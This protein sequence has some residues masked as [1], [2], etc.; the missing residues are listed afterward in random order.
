M[1]SVCLIASLVLLSAAAP[2]AVA[3]EPGAANE[4]VSPAL[5]SIGT[6][7]RRVERTD[8]RFVLLPTGEET[9]RI[10]DSAYRTMGAE[11]NL[12]LREGYNCY[13]V[14]FEHAHALIHCQIASAEDF[15]DHWI[16]DAR[17]GTLTHVKPTPNE[18]H[19]YYR[20][21][22]Y[23]L[24]GFQDFPARAPEGGYIYFLNWWTGAFRD[25]DDFRVGGPRDLDS[26]RLRPLKKRKS[27]YSLFWSNQRKS[28]VS[29]LVYPKGRG[30]FLYLR[31]R[32]CDKTIDKR[33]ARCPRGRCAARLDPELGVVG[34]E[35]R[36]S[37]RRW[38]AGAYRIAT[39]NK[40]NWEITFPE[41]EP[42]LGV[43]QIPTKFANFLQVTQPPN[44]RAYP[45]R[46]Y[47]AR[48]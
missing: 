37:S 22:R 39:R 26:R 32:R 13:P 14:D 5:P 12:A 19:P 3:Q 42:D 1:R 25:Y 24:Q 47:E 8:G 21:G 41:D 44:Y 38:T 11:V 7:D 18:Q 20:I 16:L 35:V 2:D 28:R 29:E 30:R 17:T 15:Y 33:L 43:S 46:I 6:F 10:Y 45:A 23:W 31:E 36:W 40:L 4:R 34:W 27:P 48:W 9:Y